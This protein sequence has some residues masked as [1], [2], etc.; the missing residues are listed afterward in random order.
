MELGDFVVSSVT[1]I[2]GQY[3]IDCPGKKEVVLSGQEFRSDSKPARSESFL[4]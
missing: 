4:G 3:G 1:F 2:G